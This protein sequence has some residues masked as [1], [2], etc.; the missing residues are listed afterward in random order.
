MRAPARLTPMSPSAFRVARTPFAVVPRRPPW[1]ARSF[2]NTSAN[3]LSDT[4]SMCRNMRAKV[5]E[6][7]A[8]ITRAPA[9]RSPARVPWAKVTP[10][11]RSDLWK[12]WA[13]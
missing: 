13:A 7:S 8:A 9:G 10:C 3:R 11:P 6:R 2:V 5:G 4:W 1:T 12:T